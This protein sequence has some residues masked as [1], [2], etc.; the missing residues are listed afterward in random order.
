M[1]SSESRMVLGV[2]GGLGDYFD[3]DATIVRVVFVLG[4]LG[5]GSTVLVYIVLAFIMPSAEM[6]EA[7]PRDAARGTITEAT[8]EIRS[9]INWLRERNPFGSKKNPEPPAS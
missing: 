3:V 7:H 5:F 8:D 2:C 6:A 9:A 4:A 1:R